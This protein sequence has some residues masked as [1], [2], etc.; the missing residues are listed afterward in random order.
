MQ[1]FIFRS[2]DPVHIR[3]SKEA[4]RLRDTQKQLVEQSLEEERKLLI[5]SPQ[6]VA[7]QT[8]Y[9][10][11]SSPPNVFRRLNVTID[12]EE[13]MQQLKNERISEICTFSPLI[14]EIDPAKYK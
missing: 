1:S 3:L 7:K 6:L 13:R 5:F 10:S 2:A 12:T 14:N 11:K 9:S 4:D 8:E